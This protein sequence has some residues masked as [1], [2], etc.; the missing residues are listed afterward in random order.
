LSQ[1][2]LP[3]ADAMHQLDAGDRDRCVTKLLQAKHHG[4]AVLDAPMVLL[5]R[6]FKYFDERRFVSVGS[7]PSAFQLAYRTV[8]RGVAVQCDRL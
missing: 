5:N 4:D 1:P 7:E 3:L 2:D 6:L 8:G